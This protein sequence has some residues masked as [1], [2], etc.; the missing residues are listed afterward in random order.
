M[1]NDKYE[2]L[3]AL[4]KEALKKHPDI[5]LPMFK[6]YYYKCRRDL[7]ALDERLTKI[8]R[9]KYIYKR[10]REIAIKYNKNYETIRR[11][12]NRNL[13]VEINN[14]TNED[15]N[16]LDEICNNYFST[17]FFM[18][19]VRKYCEEN[20][21]NCERGYSAIVNHLNSHNINVTELN[22]DDEKASNAI[23]SYF[24]NIYAKDGI[25]INSKF[26][27]KFGEDKRFKNFN[28]LYIALSPKMEYA[29]ALRAYKESNS[30]EEFLKRINRS[31][32]IA[33]NKERLT[34]IAKKY[35]MTY[36]SLY[37]NYV[38][39]YLDLRLNDFI[40]DPSLFD[41]LDKVVEQTKK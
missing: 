15:L 21:I 20:K 16:K 8:E 41:I 40:E 11:L 5:T 6:M 12:M 2:E 32:I 9:R 22:L 28:E 36:S 24:Q 34:K 17:N 3:K 4:Y 7:V 13:N 19:R 37:S 25:G 35:N 33:S 39:D 23:E 27:F 31:K 1:K 38:K 29:S 30:K 10:I 26:K 14:M 18:S